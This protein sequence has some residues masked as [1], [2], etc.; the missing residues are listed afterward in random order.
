VKGKLANGVGSQYS[1][2]TLKH[3]VSSIT[4]TDVQTLAASSWLNWR[5]RLFKWTCP[6]QRKTKSGFWACAITFQTHCNSKF[7]RSGNTVF[8]L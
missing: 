6:F 2:A 3:G 1:H 7:T 8:L 4:T 5:P